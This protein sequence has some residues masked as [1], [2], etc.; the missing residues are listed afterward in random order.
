MPDTLTIRNDG[1]KMVEPNYWQSGLARAGTCY[2]STQAGCFRLLLRAACRRGAGH[3]DG[4]ALCGVAGSLS[5]AAHARCPRT[6][7]R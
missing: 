5:R 3:A 7:V 1:P 4:L 6:P 2:L